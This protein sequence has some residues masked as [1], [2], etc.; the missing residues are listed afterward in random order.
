M[1][2]FLIGAAR[3]AAGRKRGIMIIKTWHLPNG[4]WTAEG[5]NKPAWEGGRLHV[6]GELET[7][8]EAIGEVAGLIAG[9][10]A[11]WSSV[12]ARLARWER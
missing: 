8:L 2:G 3:E 6:A 4:K 9:F 7:E 5:Y 11:A 12:P 10:P 1:R